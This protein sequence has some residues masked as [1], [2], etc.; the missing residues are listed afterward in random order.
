[1]LLERTLVSIFSYFGSLLIAFIILVISLFLIVQ[2]PILSI[3]EQNMIRRRSVE[4]TKEIKV[5]E[6]PPPKPREEEPKE[7]K[8]VQESL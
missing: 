3:L 4:R 1:M 8:V 7:K 5:V 2:V 6:Q